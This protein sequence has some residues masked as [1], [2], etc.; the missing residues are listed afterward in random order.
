M[1]GPLS[2]AP[3]VGF[4]GFLSFE[5]IFLSQK[6]LKTAGKDPP[7][8]KTTKTENH[9]KLQRVELSYPQNLRIYTWKLL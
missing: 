5:V 8:L 7:A 2:S 9:L 1:A 4:K 6:V 3:F